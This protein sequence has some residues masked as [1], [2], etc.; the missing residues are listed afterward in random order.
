M[1]TCGGF[2]GVAGL[3]AGAVAAGAG[4]VVAAERIAIGRT[5][6]LR[7]TAAPEN[8]ASYGDSHSR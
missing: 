7:R 3:A 1:A 8:W 4:A 2:T 6:M 5:Q